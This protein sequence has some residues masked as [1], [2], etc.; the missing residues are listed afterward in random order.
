MRDIF[1]LVKLII[2]QMDDTE[3]KDH[4]KGFI[5]T[6]KLIA[7]F[8]GVFALT[9]I[10]CW[11]VVYRDINEIQS[12]GVAFAHG[13]TITVFTWITLD[14]SG[15]H[16]NPAITLA[17]IVNNKIE[18]SLGI[19]YIL[20]HFIGGMAGAGFIYIQMTDHMI[21]TVEE[22]SVIGI[23]KPGSPHYDVSGFWA[24]L[25]GTFFISYVYMALFV[26]CHK[27]KSPDWYPMVMGMMVY[28]CM[29]TLG[30]ISGGAFNPA[31]A[32][33][34]AIMSGQIGNIQINQFF[35]A[36]I[37]GVLGSVFYS[38][39][40]MDENNE[41]DEEIEISEMG[42][43]SVDDSLMREYVMPPQSNENDS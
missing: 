13:L 42:D 40:F 35:G 7:E 32:M 9:Y 11:V 28:I 17:M 12:A 2:L 20:T 29:L 26:D 24:E 34:P 30:E 38:S 5:D 8:L 10:G 1:K 18:W 19:F 3:N 25:L 41:D 36:F 37:G 16:F 43:S 27:K 33:G 31:R 14:I 6:K 23:P 15:S 21:T 4:E 39:V 22:K